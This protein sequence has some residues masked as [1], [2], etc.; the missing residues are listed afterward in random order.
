MRQIAPG[1]WACC[2]SGD[3][4]SVDHVN[5]GGSA[6]REPAHIDGKKRC[7]ANNEIK[8]LEQ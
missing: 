2:G 6:H 4:L 7:Y 3:A 8:L 1:W 5:G